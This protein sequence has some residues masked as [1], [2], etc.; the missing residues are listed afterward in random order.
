VVVSALLASVLAL[1]AARR[2]A[3]SGPA[4]SDQAQPLPETE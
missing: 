3:Q 2:A 1:R 4:A